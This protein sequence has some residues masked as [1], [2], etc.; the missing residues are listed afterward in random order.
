M[1]LPR[2]LNA[3]EPPAG[4]MIEAAAADEPL[5]EPSLSFLSP[6]LNNALRRFHRE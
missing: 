6:L 5:P 3:I 2:V 4:A 1:R